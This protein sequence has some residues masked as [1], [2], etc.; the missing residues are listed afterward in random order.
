M[1][2]EALLVFIT[3]AANVN[4]VSYGFYMIRLLKELELQVLQGLLGLI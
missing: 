2:Q 4:N 1:K 3:A